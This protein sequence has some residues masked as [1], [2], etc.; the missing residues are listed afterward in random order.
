M[1]LYPHKEARELD[2]AGS[3][4]APEAPQ[5]IG[6]HG[7]TTRLL[8]IDFLVTFDFFRQSL[9]SLSL[10]PLVGSLGSFGAL[11]KGGT[12]SAPRS[13]GA[14]PCFRTD[15]EPRSAVIRISGPPPTL[16]FSVLVRPST[17]Y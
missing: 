6:A 4:Y 14:V 5:E 9:T 10:R 7:A 3:R 11:G 12:V 16:P 1:N 13:L 15:T 8:N 2:G 17:S